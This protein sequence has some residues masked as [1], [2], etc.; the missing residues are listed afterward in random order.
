[1][2]KIIPIRILAANI[3]IMEKRMRQ[4]PNLPILALNIKIN[5]INEIIPDIEVARAK[6]ATF[7]GNISII[8]SMIFTTNVTSEILA[9]VAVSLSA[10]K[11]HWEI[12][13]AP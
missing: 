9:G 1:M 7:R 11:Q 12:L 5:I 8:L 2:N 10:K 6:P 4:P 3:R 13:F